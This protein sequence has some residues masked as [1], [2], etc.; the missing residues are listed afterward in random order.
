MT[1]IQIRG[2][3]NRNVPIRK[4]PK[5]S[6]PATRSPLS[7]YKSA[8]S[9]TINEDIEVIY[10]LVMFQNDYRKIKK[11]CDTLQG[12]MYKAMPMTPHTNGK[13][14]AIKRTDKQ[15]LHEG[16]AIEDGFSFCVSEN[17]LNEAMILRHLTVYNKPINACIVKFIDFFESNDSYFLVTEFIESEMNLKQFVAASRVHIENGTLSPIHYQ[18]IMR[19]LMFQY[20]HFFECFCQCVSCYN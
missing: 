14:V 1:L 17:I 15:L 16:I 10:S 8:Y 13:Y 20:V 7:S 19:Y 4:L 5:P 6:K 2:Y 9:P 3:T 11:I 18:K 12:E